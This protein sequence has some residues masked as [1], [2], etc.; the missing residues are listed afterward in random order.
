MVDS[1]QAD[2]TL[3]ALPAR[4]LD[5]IDTVVEPGLDSAFTI[6][7][8]EETLLAP[9]GRPAVLAYPTALAIVIAYYRYAVP[10]SLST[11]HV[12]VNATAVAEEVLVH[13]EASA[14]GPYR[15]HVLLDPSWITR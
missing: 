14:Y 4:I 8:A 11:S 6:G 7:N 13:D 15:R 1:P 3:V 2:Y 10:A 12:P 9:T 5:S